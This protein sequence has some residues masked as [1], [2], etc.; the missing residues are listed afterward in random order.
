MSK[1][2][3]RILLHLLYWVSYFTFAVSIFG[4]YSNSYQSVFESTLFILPF[5][6]I[7]A[8]L[9]MYWVI[10][11][12]LLKKK[13]LISLVLFFVIPITCIALQR[14]TIKIVYVDILK[15]ADW[16]LLSL[17]KSGQIIIVGMEMYI[18]VTVA[19][20]IKLFKYWYNTEYT[21]AQLE[22]QNLKGELALL[23][24][25]INPHFLFNTLNN[26]NSMIK[27]TPDD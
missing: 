25:Q 2:T 7:S 10:P 13:Y 9:L 8:Y 6:M 27:R 4:F 17:I 18:V 22:K 3:H 14:I 23:R 21:K 26:I 11:K 20:A 19:C 12:F 5:I 16:T 1:S 15:L 24:S